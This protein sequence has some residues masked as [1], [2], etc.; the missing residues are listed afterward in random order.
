MGI[1]YLFSCSTLMSRSPFSS[2]RLCSLPSPII[3][4]RSVPPP[5][6]SWSTKTVGT[7]RMPVRECRT[8]WKGTQN[9]QD[10]TN[11]RKLEYINYKTKYF[12]SSIQA[13]TC[14]Q[15][16]V[17]QTSMKKSDSCTF[18]LG[19]CAQNSSISV[20]GYDY[21]RIKVTLDNIF[22]EAKKKGLH[23]PMVRHINLEE[24][25]IPGPPFPFPSQPSPPPFPSSV[26]L[27][28]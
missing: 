27:S 20:S 11:E 10:V 25:D 13:S 22:R 14:L 28:S 8:S 9:V 19:P 1:C 15:Q 26:P 4:C 3:F 6:Y 7:V 5:R 17:Q 24:W 2:R 18:S 12:S 21:R 23:T 16:H